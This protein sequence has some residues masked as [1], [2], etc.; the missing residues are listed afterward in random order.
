MSSSRNNSARIGRT[1]RGNLPINPRSDRSGQDAAPN[2]IGP[3]DDSLGMSRIKDEQRRLP[4]RVRP[5]GL[6]AHRALCL[7]AQAALEPSI[8][9]GSVVSNHS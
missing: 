1:S 3:S 2:P 8:S 6:E 4:T 5:V 9:A 7:L